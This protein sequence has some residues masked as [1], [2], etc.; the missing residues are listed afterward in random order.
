LQHIVAAANPTPRK[1]PAVAV[2]DALPITL[3]VA[4][5]QVDVNRPDSPAAFA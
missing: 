2:T 3:P 4:G 1:T 5:F